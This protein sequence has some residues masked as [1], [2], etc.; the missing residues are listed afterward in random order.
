MNPLGTG[1]VTT[2]YTDFLGTGP[3]AFAVNIFAP[4]GIPARTIDG[5]LTLIHS[6]NQGT[7]TG[8]RRS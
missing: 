2:D 8:Q 6:L 3:M 1:E 7:F 4:S 5:W